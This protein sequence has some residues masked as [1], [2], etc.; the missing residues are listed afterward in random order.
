MNV[1][2]AWEQLSPKGVEIR[3]LMGGATCT[4]PAFGEIVDYEVQQNAINM[5]DTTFFVGVHQTLSISGR[6]RQTLWG[7]CTYANPKLL[8]NDT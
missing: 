7:G 3:T 1:R 6:N 8:L 4:Q 5:A 2:D